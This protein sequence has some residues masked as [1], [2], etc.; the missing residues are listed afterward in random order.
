MQAIFFDDTNFLMKSIA[1]IDS[2]SFLK[3][4]KLEIKRHICWGIV[5]H[6][7]LASNSFHKWESDNRQMV[8][9]DGWMRRTS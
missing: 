2:F 5:E 8:G 6:T 3:K 4:D 7:Y 1:L 9:I